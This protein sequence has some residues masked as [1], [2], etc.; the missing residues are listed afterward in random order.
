MLQDITKPINHALVEK[1]WKTFEISEK[2]RSYYVRCY[3][4]SIFCIATRDCKHNCQQSTEASSWVKLARKIRI[5]LQ[6]SSFLQFFWN[7]QSSFSFTIMFPPP[8][9]HLSFSQSYWRPDT[10][11]SIYTVHM[12][13]YLQWKFSH[14]K[15]QHREEGARRPA[16]ERD[17]RGQESYPVSSCHNRWS[18]L[19]TSFKDERNLTFLG[20]FWL[21]LLT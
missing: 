2:C 15:E 8:T 9:L 7:I 14:I 5:K 18:S 20:E 1:L 11:K 21:V 10:E 16:R 12:C 6:Q 13:T 4:V 3:V 17:L 19:T